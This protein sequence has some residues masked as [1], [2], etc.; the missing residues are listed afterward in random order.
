MISIISIILTVL[1]FSLLI[2]VHELGHFTTAKLSGVTVNEFWLGMG[3]TIFKKHYKGTDYCLKALPFGGAVVMEG[4][5]YES[6]KEGSLSS[7]PKINKALILVAGSLMNFVL[8]FII[9]FIITL[10]MNLIETTTLAELPTGFKYSDSLKQGD[11][12]MKIDEFE[13]YDTNDVITALNHNQAQ[14]FDIELLRGEEKVVLD[15]FSFEPAEYT[16]ENGNTS[17]RFGLNFDTREITFME[18]IEH[19]FA[20]CTYYAKMVW[21]SLGQ[22]VSGNVSVNELS[23]PVGITVMI[24]EAAEIS[25]SA[26]WS[27]VAFISINLGVMN[28]LPLPALDGGRLLLLGVEAIRR[29]PLNPTIEGYIHGGGLIVLLGLMLYVTFHD[30]FFK[31]LG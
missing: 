19:V 10:P 26:M 12:I 15:N 27:F 2:I 25:M 24:G 30:I 20:T 8:G 14:I 11:T 22:L 7:A 23:G 28:L 17:M 1:V 13:I 21:Q 16:D 31:I 29:K 5:D 4:E 18:K 9:I 3:P 6:N